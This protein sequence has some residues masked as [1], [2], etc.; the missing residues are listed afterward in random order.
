MLKIFE[1]MFDKVLIDLFPDVEPMRFVWGP[2]LSPLRTE[3]LGL[4]R[5]YARDEIRLNE[6]REEYYAGR[7]F[8]FWA[9]PSY[10]LNVRFNH[11]MDRLEAKQDRREARIAAIA[12]KLERDGRM[13]GPKQTTPGA[14]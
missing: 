14:L 8:F 7:T 6:L 4:K 13:K 1:K 5:N 10:R 3:L 12:A 2:A 11:P 9:K